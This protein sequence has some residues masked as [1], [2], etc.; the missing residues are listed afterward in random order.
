MFFKIIVTLMMMRFPMSLSLSQKI[1]NTPKQSQNI[2]FHRF[3][4]KEHNSELKSPLY[5]K[6]KLCSKQELPQTP[7][8]EKLQE[9]IFYLTV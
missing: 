7:F 4:I 3:L 5:L 9:G 2:Y 1:K 8:T 6:A